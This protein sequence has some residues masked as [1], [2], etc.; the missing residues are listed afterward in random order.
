M[1]YC[2]MARSGDAEDSES[3]PGAGGSQWK[4]WKSLGSGWETGKGSEGCGRVGRGAGGPEEVQKVVQ[5]CE[6]GRKAQEVTVSASKIS[7][8][9]LDLV[10]SSCTAMAKFY[11]QL[12]AMC[13]HPTNSFIN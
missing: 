8:R 6:R 1:G 9:H 5:K 2:S 13:S 10:I 7:C 11:D 12:T 4:P 3:E